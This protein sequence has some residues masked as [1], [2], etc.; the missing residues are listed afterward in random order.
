M[1]DLVILRVGCKILVPFILLYALY[2]QAHGDLGPGG[3]FQAGVIFAAGIVLYGLIYG[4]EAAEQAMRPWV[5]RTFVALG[6]MIYIGTGYVGMLIG[7]DFLEYHVLRHDPN[8]GIHL[9]I[10]SV[11][12]GVGITVSAVMTTIFYEFAEL[13]RRHG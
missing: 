5:V 4:L 12:L 7:G 8:H 3:G 1:S 13:R 2:V 11:E 9:G 6:V 10:F